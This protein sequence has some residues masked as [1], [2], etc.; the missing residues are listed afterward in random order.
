MTP[1][2]RPARAR[3]PRAS[4]RTCPPERL[5][6][7]FVREGEGY[8]IKKEVRDLVVFAPQN[9]LVDPPFTK[10]DILCC[11]NLLIYVNAETQKKLLPLMHYALN[12]GGLLILGTAESIGGFGHLFSPLDT[13]MEGLPTQGSAASEAFVEMPASRLRHERAAVP[14]TEK[15]KEPVMDIFYA[16]QRVLLDCYGPP[17]VVVTAEGDIIYVN[18]RT[19]KYLEPSSGKVNVNVFAM[20]REGLREELGM[21]IHNAAQTEDHRHPER[22]EGQVQRR[23]D[24]RSTSRSGR[25]PSRRTCGAC[26]WSC[27]RKP[28]PANPRPPRRGAAPSGTGTPAGRSGGGTPPHARA[29][30]DH[31]RGNA[32]RPR[33]TPLRQRGVAVE[34]RGI[35]EHQ[36]RIDQFQG[37]TA[38]A[39]RRDADRERRVAVEDRGIVAVQQRHEEPLERHRDRHDLPGRRPLASSG[40]LPRPRGSSTWLPATWGGR[41]ATSPRI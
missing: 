35:A 24:D 17:S 6:R 4:P 19:G 2:R 39:Q 5:A 8:R 28:R 41:S 14:V 21:A 36:R 26:S 23:L 16:A 31:R 34:Q 27:S 25:W 33:G 29:P 30:S 11:R 32:G 1:S 7:F 10:L 38:I 18:G 22:R 12:P 3:S 9:I 15:A 37:G 13:E 20:A 40:S